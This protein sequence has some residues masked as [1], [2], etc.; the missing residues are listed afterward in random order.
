MQNSSKGRLRIFIELTNQI[1]EAHN[2][3]D[4]NNNQSIRFIIC[5][6]PKFPFLFPRVYLQN[7]LIETASL[8]DGR[9]FIENIIGG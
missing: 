7:A 4:L 8:S 1:L 5:L 2:L 3:L 9:D 6:D